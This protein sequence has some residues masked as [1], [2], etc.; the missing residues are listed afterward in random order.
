M[1]LLVR[2]TWWSLK[3]KQAGRGMASVGD[4]VCQADSQVSE[5]VKK[6]YAKTLP[7]LEDYLIQIGLGNV[8][9]LWCLPHQNNGTILP[10]LP[11]CIILFTTT[12][13]AQFDMIKYDIRTKNFWPTNPLIKRILTSFASRSKTSKAQAPPNSKLLLVQLWTMDRGWMT[14]KPFF[15]HSTPQLGCA[16]AVRNN[17]HDGSLK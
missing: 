2:E 12:P 10:V 8:S 11:Y 4:T 17:M 9:L 7:H 5:I 13:A 1:L 3:L 16:N 6:K 15:C 14:C